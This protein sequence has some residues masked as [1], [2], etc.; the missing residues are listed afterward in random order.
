MPRG[1]HFLKPLRPKAPHHPT[2][3]PLS[4]L[5]QD[6][7][8]IRRIARVAERRAVRVVPD[9]VALRAG[10]V[11]RVGDVAAARREARHL[12]GDLPRAHAPRQR[13]QAVAAVAHFVEDH[14]AAQRY[15]EIIV[16]RSL[17]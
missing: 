4:G 5:T 3:P 1:L 11:R 9:E 6:G 13:H 2:Q 7:L 12:D 14:L 8:H 16:S 17:A 15:P 10:D